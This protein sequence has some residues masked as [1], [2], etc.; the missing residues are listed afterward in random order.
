MIHRF[1]KQ[2][3]DSISR[4]GAKLTRT[5]LPDEDS[6]STEYRYNL[7]CKTTKEIHFYKDGLIESCYGWHLTHNSTIEA[8]DENNSRI[9]TTAISALDF[10]YLLD[11]GYRIFLHENGRVG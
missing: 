11:K 1:D 8:I 2:V 4:E 5:L 9:Y 3:A 7:N 10:S 6:Y